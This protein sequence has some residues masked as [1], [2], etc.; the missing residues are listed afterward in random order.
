MTD[1][2]RVRGGGAALVFLLFSVKVVEIALAR[3]LPSGGLLSV[4]VRTG[5]DYPRYNETLGSQ[6]AA[7]T[8]MSVNSK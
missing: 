7:L 1:A 3:S 4:Q 2:Q 5:R 8:S 6:Q